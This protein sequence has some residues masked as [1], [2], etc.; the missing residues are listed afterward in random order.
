MGISPRP[1][2]LVTCSLILSLIRPAIAMVCPSANSTVEPALLLVKA[3]TKR[4]ELAPGTSI[5]TAVCDDISLTETLIFRLICLASSTTGRKS[6][7]IPKSLYS[8]VTELFWPGTGTGNS[9][10]ARKTA[11]CPDNVVRVGSASTLA[12][13]SF[14]VAFRTKLYNMLPSRKLPKMPLLREAASVNTLL[15]EPRPAGYRAGR[16]VAPLPM[17]PAISVPAEF[18]PMASNF[19]PN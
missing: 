2:I 15:T 14:F 8:I 9:P 10:P 11:G 4:P 13:P 12:T 16:V 19:I 17:T 7:A 18:I 5:A 3:G 6:I 1:G